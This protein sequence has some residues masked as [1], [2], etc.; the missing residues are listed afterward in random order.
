MAKN[1]K[2]KKM[3]KALFKSHTIG[4]LESILKLKIGGLPRMLIN[5][6]LIEFGGRALLAKAQNNK[7]NNINKDFFISMFYISPM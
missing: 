2:R 3:N 6:T 4:H 1:W 5:F 7:K